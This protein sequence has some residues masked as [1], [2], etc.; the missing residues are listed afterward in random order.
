MLLRGWNTITS[1]EQAPFLSAIQSF[2]KYVLIFENK[3]SS[4]RKREVLET[5]G[6]FELKA[7]PSKSGSM[8]SVE[9]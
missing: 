8:L 7:M 1:F 5:E 4:F 3:I 2:L 6:L 9:I